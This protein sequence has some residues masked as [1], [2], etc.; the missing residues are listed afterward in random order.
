[1]PRGIRNQDVQGGRRLR[2]AWN[3]VQRLNERLAKKERPN[4][5]RGGASEPNVLFASD[6][7]RQPAAPGSI[8]TQ[9]IAAERHRG[10]NR[11]GWRI[12]GLLK[13]K[14]AL[15]ILVDACKP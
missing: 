10:H 6:P 14:F 5:I 15:T 1:M 4:S 3:I 2:S 8:V 12:L 9:L 11:F 7:M 13:L